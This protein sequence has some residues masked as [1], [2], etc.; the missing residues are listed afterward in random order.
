MVRHKVLIAGKS[1]GA[2]QQT[3]NIG[4][5]ASAVSTIA[6]GFNPGGR[7]SQHFQACGIA[8][9][10]ALF[11]A[12]NVRRAR[13][14]LTC[15]CTLHAY[16]PSTPQHHRIPAAESNSERE[17]CRRVTVS[18]SA[19][20]TAQPQG[21]L[22][23]I[24][25]AAGASR[26][27][28]SAKQLAKFRRQPLV[29]RA[30]RLAEAVCGEQSLLVAGNQW[31]LVAAA[32]APL[33][34][35]F[36]V[37]PDFAEGLGGSIAAGVSAVAGSASGILLLMADQPLID[38]RHLRDMV[39]AWSKNSQCIV[40]SEFDGIDG[41]PVIFPASLF[42]DLVALRGD[43]GARMVLQANPARVIRVKCPDA[44]TDVDIPA[45]L[46]AIDR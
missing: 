46:Q 17:V 28:G 14:C 39:E 30:I 8:H 23:C 32:C 26:R 27:F 29:T 7:G 35:Y 42:P 4:N 34:G 6:A 22:F 19:S 16:T 2:A 10:A 43:S 13:L 37:N 1:A 9:Y 18:S 33:A 15:V 12:R 5:R 45:D 40:V 38:A 44:A 36:V 41:P 31:S 21:G 11:Q 3:T 20:K 25:L 24:V